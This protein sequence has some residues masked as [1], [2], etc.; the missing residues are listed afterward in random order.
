MS[1]DPILVD[2]VFLERSQRALTRAAARLAAFCEHVEHNEANSIADAV[3]AGSCLRD[4]ASE[5]SVLS[6]ISLRAAYVERIQRIE[7]RSLL[8]HLPP[9]HNT[10]D[11]P[12]VAALASATTWNELQ[13]G[14][15]VHDRLFHPDVFGLPKIEQIRHYTLHVTKLAGL[16]VDALEGDDWESFKRDRLADIAIFGVKI[17]TV[18]NFELPNSEVDNSPESS[19][20]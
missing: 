20:I 18:C 5:L 6:R 11:L 13:S 9:D 4:I 8:R 1:V 15:I 10:S 16:L 3:T 19:V 14:Q 17:A 7:E 2:R 12:G